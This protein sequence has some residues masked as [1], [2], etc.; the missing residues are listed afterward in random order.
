MAHVLPTSV[1]SHLQRKKFFYS[2]KKTMNA[3]QASHLQH[4]KREIPGL[5]QTVKF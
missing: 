5:L 3:F 4:H 1:A 2:L